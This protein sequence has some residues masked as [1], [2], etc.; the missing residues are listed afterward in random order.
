MADSNSCVFCQIVAGLVPARTVYED[1]DH[2]AF[3]PLEHINPGHVV[4]IPK[5][6]TDYLFDLTPSAYESL[7]ATAARIA[8]PLKDVMSAKR[9]GVAVEGFSV[10]HV[11]VH[12]VPIYAFDDLNPSRAKA[13]DAAEADRLH[14][15]I[16]EALMRDCKQQVSPPPN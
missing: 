16:R 8:S 14:S 1:G 7:W 10:P 2:V 11:H 13:L 4:L 3:F 5:Q 6:H 12:L 9:V 15:L